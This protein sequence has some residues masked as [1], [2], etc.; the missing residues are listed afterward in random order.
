MR[1]T[2]TLTISLP[3][4]MAAQMEEVQRQENRTRSELVRE[5]LRQYFESRYPSVTPTKAD[6]AAIRKGRAAYK[7]GDYVRLK[8]LHDELEA[9]SHQTRAKGTRKAT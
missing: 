5:A 4:A 3:P 8:Q 2:E 9:A 6:I 1:T 7:R